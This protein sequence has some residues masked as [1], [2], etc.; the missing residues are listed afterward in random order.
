M[1]SVP[2]LVRPV[3]RY[4][5]GTYRLRVHVHEAFTNNE[6]VVPKTSS[7]IRAETCFLRQAR[8]LR[9]DGTGRDGTDRFGS[10]AN[11]KSY[12]SHGSQWAHQPPRRGGGLLESGSSRRRP[13]DWTLGVG[14]ADAAIACTPPPTTVG[15][16]ALRCAARSSRLLPA[17]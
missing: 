14:Y 8:Q 9:R 12:S 6:W 2:V 17:Q 10:S 4:G 7:Y 5:I 16:A 13:T 3:L 11:D 1:V 15:Y